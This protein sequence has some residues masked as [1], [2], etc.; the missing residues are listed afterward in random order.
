VTAAGAW[1]AVVIGI[2][3]GGWGLAEAVEWWQGKGG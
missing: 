1:A 3:L 2:A